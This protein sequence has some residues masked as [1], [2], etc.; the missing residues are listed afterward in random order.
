[1]SFPNPTASAV[2]IQRGEGIISGDVAPEQGVSA[3]N[4]YLPLGLGYLTALTP[5]VL[6]IYQMNQA[7]GDRLYWEDHNPLNFESNA[8]W[9]AALVNV[10]KAEVGLGRAMIVAGQAM[11]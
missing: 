4:Q 10:R 9:A 5:A 6:A 2:L 1:M 3:V 7:N 11:A 8:D